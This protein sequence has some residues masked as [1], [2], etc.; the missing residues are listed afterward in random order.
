MSFAPSDEA[1]EDEDDDDDDSDDDDNDVCVTTAV[2]EAERPQ[3]P[4]ARK[5]GSGRAPSPFFLTQQTTAR[6][7]RGA[8]MASRNK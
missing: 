6:E 8:R 5:L 1:S 3:Q 2:I 4:R 7:A